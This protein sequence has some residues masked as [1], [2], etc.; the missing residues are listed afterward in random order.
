MATLLDLPCG[1]KKDVPVLAVIDRLQVLSAGKIEL[2]SVEVN[3][4]VDKVRFAG[5]DDLADGTVVIEGSGDQSDGGRGRQDGGV[6]V[7]LAISEL[8]GRLRF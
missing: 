4:V 5:P 2:L 6:L 8:F 1:L 3:Q 7:E